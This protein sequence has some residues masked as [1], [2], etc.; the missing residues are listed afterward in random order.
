MRAPKLRLV[1]KHGGDASLGT[2]A[3]AN[4]TTG[5]AETLELRERSG[6]EFRHCLLR[7]LASGRIRNND[8]CELSWHHMRSGGLGTNDLAVSPHLRG[9]NFARKVRAALGLADVRKRCYWIC[10]PLWN[11]NEAKR[12]LTWMPIMLPH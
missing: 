8:V 4:S 2:V 6:K 3:V 11:D 1:N 5:P 9:E 10:V 12:L 7:R